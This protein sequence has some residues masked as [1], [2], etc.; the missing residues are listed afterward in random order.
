MSLPLTKKLNSGI[1]M[2]VLGLGTFKSGKGE[3]GA[4]VTAALKSGYRLIDCAQGYGNQAEIGESFAEAFASGTV[5]REELFVVSKCFQTH[6]VW[7]GD[8]SRVTEMLTSALSDLKLE[9]L[10]LLLI[11]WPFAFEQKVLDFPLRLEDGSPN[12]KLNVEVEYLDTWKVFEGF[13]REGKVKSIG[14]SN[15]TEKQLEY[16]TQNSEIPPAVN[17]VEVHPYFAQ[18]AMKA[19][20]D[21]KGIAV[22]AYSPLG[23][24]TPN[25]PEQHG[26]TLMSLPLIKD[27]A[28]GLG[29]TPSQVLIRWSLQRGCISIPKSGNPERIAQNGDVLSWELSTEDMA[30]ITGLNSNFRYFISYLKKPDNNIKW[31]DDA[32]EHQPVV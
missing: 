10:D 6:H 18:E 2:P 23:S 28:D 31:H 19:Y 17:Q 3:V 8:T 12:P 30:K 26:A 1:D 13:V 15:F 14:V 27:I 16:L 9:Y 5:K 24:S 7:K 22:M 29:K 20:C 25:F 4:A 11:H 21:S 32:V